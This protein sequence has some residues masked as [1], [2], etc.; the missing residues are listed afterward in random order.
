MWYHLKSEKMLKKKRPGVRHSEIIPTASLKTGCLKSCWI[1]QPFYAS[2][3]P[4][5]PIAKL[6]AGSIGVQFSE[7]FLNVHTKEKAL[8]LPKRVTF[9]A[10]RIFNDAGDFYQVDKFQH[11]TMYSGFALSGVI[12]LL[13]LFL[14]LP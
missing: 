6:I 7:T 5:E 10:F 2:Q 11:V 8:G 13:I 12:D 1:P 3:I 14:Y 4:I 9:G